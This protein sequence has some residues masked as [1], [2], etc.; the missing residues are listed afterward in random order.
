YYNSG[1]PVDKSMN[2]VVYEIYKDRVEIS[3]YSTTGIIN[4][5]GAGYGSVGEYQ[6]DTNVYASPFT[7]VLKFFREKGLLSNNRSIDAE[8]LLILKQHLLNISE[9]DAKIA[10]YA[11]MND[12]GVVDSTDITILSTM[13]VGLS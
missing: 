6:A 7:S 2:M 13:I 10:E 12:D 9:M 11:D 4:L 8:D 5:K 3:R 1:N